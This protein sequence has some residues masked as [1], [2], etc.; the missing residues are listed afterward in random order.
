MTEID[1][2]RCARTTESRLRLTPDD[3]KLHAV[4]REQA[5]VCSNALLEVDMVSH[6]QER[7]DAPDRRIEYG[8]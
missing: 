2:V 8:P 4:R 6:P 1:V 7:P 3:E 5:G